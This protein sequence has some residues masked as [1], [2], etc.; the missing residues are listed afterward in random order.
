MQHGTMKGLRELAEVGLKD[1]LSFV[2][3]VGKG[4]C[5]GSVMIFSSEYRVLKQSQY[6][7]LKYS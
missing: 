4:G 5:I 7:A 2:V 3:E 1:W 6:R